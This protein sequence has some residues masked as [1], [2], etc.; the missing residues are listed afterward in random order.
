VR[1]WTAIIA[2]ALV[3]VYVSTAAIKVRDFALWP[4]SL[5]VLCVS[6]VICGVLLAFV[7]SGAAWSVVAASALAVLIFTG[8][9]SYIFWSFLGEY[10]SLFE[11]VIS[12]P[13]IYQVLLPS[14]MILV[15][16]VPFGLLGSVAVRIFLPEATV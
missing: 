15:T 13:F 12:T 16:T 4:T 11:I 1:Q 14:G 5:A 7:N 10:F 6:A 9:W 8:V 3:L 2:A